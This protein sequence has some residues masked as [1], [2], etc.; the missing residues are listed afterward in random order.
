MTILFTFSLATYYEPV[1]APVFA[2]VTAPAS[3]PEPAP[4]THAPVTHTHAPADENKK[5]KSPIIISIEG[6]IGTGKSTLIEKI[7]QYFDIYSIDICNTPCKFG[8][9]PEPV[10]IWNSVT[11]ND[12]VTI[13]EKYYQDQHKYAFPFQMMAYISRLSIMR[14]ALKEDYDV[15]IMERSMFTDCEVFAK[16]LYDDKKIETIEY[17]IYKK[18]FDEFIDDFP[19]IHHIYIQADPTVS[20][21]RVIKRGRQGETI[22][23]SYL[24]TCHEYHEHWLLSEEDE[25]ESI[26]LL[27]GNKELTDDD[28]DDWLCSI[29]DFIC[30]KIYDIY[31][32]EDEG[33]CDD[34]GEDECEDEGEG[35]D[36]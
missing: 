16:M 30:T 1:F 4:V 23:L 9:I 14:D 5:I 24:Q 21:E 12:G 19:E 22:P 26:L 13:L 25:Q 3:E 7:Q 27:D 17:N 35:D 33:E 15:I 34:E 10:N 18:W 36:E 29:E 8:F 32:G 31:E 20:A 6:N 11:D 2:P 28:Y